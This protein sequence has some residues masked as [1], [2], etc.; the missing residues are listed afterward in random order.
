MT[1]RGWPYDADP[2]VM[3]VLLYVVVFITGLI[4]GWWIP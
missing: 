1:D 3:T 4:I 2:Q